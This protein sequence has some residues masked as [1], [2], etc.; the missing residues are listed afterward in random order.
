M[1]VTITAFERSPD[2]GKGLAR[3]TRVRWAL[4]EAGLP[5]E[6][7]LV[8]FRAMKEAAHLALHPFGQIPTYEEGELALFETGA[9]V[10]HIAERHPG[11][12]PADANARARAVMWMF[13]ALNTVE[14]PILEI[15]TV[16][17]VEGDKP[18]KA[19]RLSLVEDRVRA[20][21]T[22]LAARLGDA[23]WLDGGFS[24]GD[25]LMVSVLLRL[26]PSGLLDEFPSLAAY[27]AR[28]EARPAYQRA[29]AAQLAINAAPAA[30]APP[31]SAG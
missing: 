21:L 12:F 25:L 1:T 30:P 6:V 29:F 15:V 16:K 20:R 28:G 18:W 10:L 3:D 2:G 23:D 13:A 31:L 11:L 8:S 7:R 9:I 26:R 17:F 14:P 4:E 22:S 27:V 5:Y 19:E 24:A